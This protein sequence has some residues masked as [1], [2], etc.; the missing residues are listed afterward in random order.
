MQSQR[1]AHDGPTITL[2]RRQA[3]V[4]REAMAD[5]MLETAETLLGHLRDAVDG[6]SRLALQD[7]RS[8]AHRIAT[9]AAVLDRLEQAEIDQLERAVA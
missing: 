5:A 9:E 7:A 8:W 4:L 6:G 2:E 1:N 3:D